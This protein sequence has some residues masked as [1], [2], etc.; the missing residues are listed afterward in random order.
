MANI[1]VTCPACKSDLEIDAA[2]EGQEV[3]C[4]NCLEVFKATVPGTGKSNTGKIPGASKSGSGSPGGSGRSTP[5]P[6]KKRRDDDDDDYE[7]DRRRDDYEDDDDDY[8]DRRRGNPPPTYLA[9]SIIV[10]LLCCWIF[11]IIAIIYAAQVESKWA[12]G[13][14]RGAY[15]ASAAARTWCWL[16]FGSVLVIL[17]IYVVIV[18]L[19]A[20]G[21]R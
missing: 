19:I 3:E 10:T 8:Y 17:A 15:A 2:F 21:G 7:H 14:T 20:V 6:K 12:R 5:T 13:D 4:G 11:G 1:R 16:S 18:A 9:Q